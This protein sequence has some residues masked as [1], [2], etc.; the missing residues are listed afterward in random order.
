MCISQSQSGQ[1]TAEAVAKL[2]QRIHQAEFYDFLSG[3]LI[4]RSKL[5]EDGGLSLIFD[6]NDGI[7]PWDVRS[8]SFHLHQK[9]LAGKIDPHLLVGVESKNKKSGSGKDVKTRNLEHNYA[10]RVSC[11]Y[12]GQGNLQNGQW[13]PLQICAMRDGGWCCSLFLQAGL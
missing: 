3:V 9:W 4:K 8:D 5:L 7:F 2:R 13:W 11:N 12:V 6:N 1:D 10:G